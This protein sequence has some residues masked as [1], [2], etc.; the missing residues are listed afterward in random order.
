VA[1][2]EGIGVDLWV[3]PLHL[4]P[5]EVY[6][7]ASPAEV[8]ARLTAFRDNKLPNA[9]PRVLQEEESGSLLVEFRTAV[10]GLLGRRKIHRT[11][12]RVTIREPDEVRFQ[13]VEGPLDL[14]SDRIF[15]ESFEGGTLVRYESTVG[16]W[17]SVFGWLLCYLYVRP[18]M[19]RFMN[20]HLKQMKQTVEGP[21]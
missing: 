8:F 7:D 18:V 5:A 14:L 10:T 1:G 12:E 4:K 21:A 16:L 6:V 2:E 9:W 15:V 19:Q 20:L 11:V 13:G 3:M 17:G